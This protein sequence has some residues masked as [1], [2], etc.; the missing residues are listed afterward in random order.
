M[1]SNL[2]VGLVYYW[3]NLQ[4]RTKRDRRTVIITY[5]FL[6]SICTIVLKV[7]IF[8]RLTAEME[9]SFLKGKH[10]G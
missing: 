6:Y 2:F 7:T 5:F 3:K 1:R 4:T 8:L 9:R 10:C